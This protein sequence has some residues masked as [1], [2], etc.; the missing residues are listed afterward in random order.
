MDEKNKSR[1]KY[2]RNLKVRFNQSSDNVVKFILGNKDYLKKY[3]KNN[4][5]KDNLL[6]NLSIKINQMIDFKRDQI[7]ELELLKDKTKITKQLKDLKSL[8]M[9]QI[10]LKRINS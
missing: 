5:N 9:A 1:K 2:N 4:D 10:E 3:Y 8:E 6:E 7:K